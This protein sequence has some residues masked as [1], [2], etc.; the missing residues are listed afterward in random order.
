M[1]NNRRDYGSIDPENGATFERPCKDLPPEIRVDFIKKTYALVF[2]MLAITFG[3]TS[4]FLIHPAAEVM[5]YMQKHSWILA[6]TGVV[7]TCMYVMNMCVVMSMFCGAGL[8]QQYMKLFKTFPINIIFLT[9]VSAC[10][11]VLMGMLTLQY[12]IQSV[13]I[14][15]AVSAALIVAL[16][17]YAIQTKADFTGMGM[18][19]LVA[20]VALMFTGL[21]C[22]ILPIPADGIMNRIFGGA[23]AMLFGFI[24]VYDTQLIFG[25]SK[26]SPHPRQIQFTVDM[27]AFAAYHLYLDF[28]NFIIYINIF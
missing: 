24:I 26:W 10:F 13:L 7:F 1:A 15:F 14:I 20:V 23:G 9:T 17:V 18:Y 12:E 25:E 5:A 2:Y 28:I 4:Q 16:T 8:Y 3:I 21:L 6:V 22:A 11:G 19:I 27:Y